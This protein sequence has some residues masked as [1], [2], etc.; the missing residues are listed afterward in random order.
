MSGLAIQLDEIDDRRVLHARLA[1]LGNHLLPCHFFHDVLVSGEPRAR[2]FSAEK[3][4]GM[5]P[6]LAEK[7]GDAPE[8]AQRLDCPRGPGAA[9]IGRLPAELIEQASHRL[10]CGRI[11]SANEHRRWAPP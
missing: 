2:R 6:L 8:N 11:V 9:H 5:R 1:E 4:E 10:L 7:P 3:L